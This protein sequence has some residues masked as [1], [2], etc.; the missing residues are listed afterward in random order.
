MADLRKISEKNSIEKKP[1][2]QIWVKKSDQYCNMRNASLIGAK[3][4]RTNK[5]NFRE[6]YVAR[7]QGE[8]DLSDVPKRVLENVHAGG[9]TESNKEVKR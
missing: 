1:R 7:V 6:K 3:N 2:K 9:A 5:N 8:L 4:V